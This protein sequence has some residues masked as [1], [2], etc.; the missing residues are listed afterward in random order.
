MLALLHK[1]LPGILLVL[2]GLVGL[3]LANLAMT[4]LSFTI[5]PPALLAPKAPPPTVA[6]TRAP[7]LADYEVILDR[8]LFDSTGGSNETLVG[9]AASSAPSAPSSSPRSRQKLDLIG[10]VADGS[11]GLALIQVS[12]DVKVLQVGDELPG[13]GTLD[14]VRRNEADIAY[15]DGSNETLRIPREGTAGATS[16]T[17]SAR[18]SARSG[19]DEYQIRSVGENRYAVARAEVEKARANIGELLKQARMEPYVVNGST[20]GFVV[21]MI[22]PDTLLSQLGLQLGDIVK[23]VNGVELNSPEKALQVFQQLREARRLTIDLTRNGQPV[24]LQYDV[25]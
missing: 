16:S 2:A 4:G 17:A 5:A 20:A 18:A 24:T 11:R 22:K 21:K 19:G 13:G 23:Q 3:S 9:K 8:N 10:T 7:E 1:N 6:P 12:G 14:A 15:R 25:N